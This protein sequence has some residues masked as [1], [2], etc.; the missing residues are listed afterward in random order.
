MIARHSPQ[1]D[2]FRRKNK[3]MNELPQDAYMLLSFVNMKLR[4]R[5]ETLAALCEDLGCDEAELCARLA[6]I[7][8]TYSP[9]Q[10]RFL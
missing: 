3:D 2:T 6:G 9:A 10:N 1:N 8:Y 5:Y 7:G 4:D